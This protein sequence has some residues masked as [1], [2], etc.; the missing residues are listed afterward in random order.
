MN[1][2]RKLRPLLTLLLLLLAVPAAANELRQLLQPLLEA[3]PGQSGR[4]PAGSFRPPGEAS[5]TRRPEAAAHEKHSLIDIAGTLSG[6][7]LYGAW[8]ISVRGQS[9]CLEVCPL[10][11]L[12]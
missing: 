9:P 1:P 11:S 3:H 12:V 8:T 5:G 10:L 7:K 6:H 4:R 2:P